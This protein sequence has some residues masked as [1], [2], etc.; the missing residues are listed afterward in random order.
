MATSGSTDFNINA[1]ELVTFA[2]K[3][4]GVIDSDETPA[5]EDMDDGITALNL[6]MKSWQIKGPHLA[7]ETFGSVSLVNATASYSL[8][9]RPY[10]IIEA[11]YRDAS[12]RDIPMLELVRQEYVDLPLK[13]ASGIPTQ[14]YVD[15]QNDAVNLYVWP[16]QAAVTTET[17]QFT[18]QRRFEDVDNK[19]NDIDIPQEWL[20]TVAYNLAERCQPIFSTNN[21]RVTARA[22]MLLDEAMDADR[23]AYIQLMPEYRYA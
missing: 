2:L 19:I 5:A 11:R 10:R 12:G 9:P 4:I 22:Q 18:Y 14:F 17:I 21:Q 23:E 8:T 1:G 7:R 13:S 6:M 20:E 16:V 3:L 15:I